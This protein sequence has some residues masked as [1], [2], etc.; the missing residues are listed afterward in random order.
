MEKIAFTLLLLWSFTAFAQN[1]PYCLYDFAG[2]YRLSTVNTQTGAISQ[3]GPIPPVAFYVL[4]N[5]QCIS[6]HD[7]TYIFAGHDGTDVRLYTITLGA[8]NVVYNPVFN[9]NVVGLEYNCKDSTIYA[10]EENGGAY[11]LVRVDNSTGTTT[12]I[13]TVSGVTAYVGDSFTIDEKRGLYHFFG[14]FGGNIKM[15]SIDIKTGVVTASP[16]FP[17]NVT[18]LAYNCSDSTIYGLWEDGTDYKLEKLNPLTGT[19]TTVG[20]LPN[21]DPGFVAESATI[22]YNG[23]YVYR[24]FSNTQSVLVTIDVKTANVLDT[25]SFTANI[26]GLDYYVCCNEPPI[27]V[28]V[29]ENELQQ[30]KIYPNPVNDELTIEL[31]SGLKPK[32][33]ELYDVQ[34]KQVYYE[35]NIDRNKIKISFKTIP[36]GLYMV[37][38]IDEVNKLWESKIIAN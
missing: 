27:S 25:T 2:W 30:L 38:V 5:K 3:I 37:R 12:Q 24:G 16:F 1:E 10:M 15:Y 31:E 36:A 7:S 14:L 20:I 26:S 6:T 18:G 35:D 8:A 21:I 32:R 9:S 28:S 33:I 13:G 11:D 23:E 29:E 34:G 22:N 17:D 19:H 4:G